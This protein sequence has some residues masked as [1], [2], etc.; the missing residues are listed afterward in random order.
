MKW[1]LGAGVLLAISLLLGLGLFAYAM[2]ALLAAMLVSRLLARSWTENLIGRARVQPHDRQ[3]RRNGGRGDHAQKFRLAA[4]RLG[5][6]R[7]RAAPPGVDVRAAQPADPRA[8]RAADQPGQPRPRQHALS[9]GVQSARLLS[10]RSAG[11]GDGRPVRPAPPVSTGQP[12]AFPDGLS[13]GGAAGRIRDR[14]AP[15]AGR[16]P[17]DAPACSKIQPASPACGAT[18]PATR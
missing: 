10:D 17:H 4:G 11:D 14:L 15:A 1:F 2:Y 18:K 12:A 9:V 7:R 8:A 6:D 16:D 5:A 13:P 3:R